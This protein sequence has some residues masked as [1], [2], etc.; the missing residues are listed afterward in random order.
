MGGEREEK[1]VGLGGATS[2]GA[3]MGGREGG[4]KLP[5]PPPLPAAAPGRYLGPKVETAAPVG[6]GGEGG[7]PWVGE[8]E[9]K[10]RRLGWVGHPWVGVNVWGRRGHPVGEV[11]VWG[12]GWRWVRVRKGHPWVGGW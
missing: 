3:P 8:C 5:F 11:N 4:G 10:G 2:E 6:G 12:V 1:E 9:G 7:L